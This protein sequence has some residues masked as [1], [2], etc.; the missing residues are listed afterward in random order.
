MEYTL[1]MTFVGANGEKSTISI[2]G[3]KEELN[4][5]EASAL[6]DTLI[7]QDIFVTKNGNLVSKYSAEL[8]KRQVDKFEVA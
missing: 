8:I 4:Q 7:E 1:S 2:T 5:E 6:M 3:V